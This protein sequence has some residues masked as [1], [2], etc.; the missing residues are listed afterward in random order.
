LAAP[1]SIH[2]LLDPLAT[3]WPDIEQL[4]ESDIERAPRRFVGG[5]NSWIA[6]TFL[7]LRHSLDER[8]WKVTAGPHVE[9]GAITVVHRDDANDFLARRHE[10]FLVVVRADRPPVV[11]CDLAIVQNGISPNGNE[12]FVPLWPQPGLVGRERSRGAGIERIAYHGR[13]SSAP[14]W[15][16]DGEFRRQLAARSLHFDIRVAEWED[17]RAV[18]VAIAARDEAPGVLETKPATKLYNAWIAGVPV[19]AYPE[20][21]YCELRHSAIDFMAIHDSSDVLRCVDLLRANP[22]LYARMA[23]N[24]LRRGKDFSIDAI[25]RRWLDLFDEEIIPSFEEARL[26]VPARRL[27]FVG[28]MVRQKALSRIHKFRVARERAAIH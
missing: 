25:R 15:F 11:A 9:P 28:A 27:W 17:Y 6:Q 8:G 3:R 12:R 2:F 26:R 4:D 16:T 7:R 21:A 19:L 24:G 22:S 1:R 14:E 18:D 20:P 23:A 13:I 10:T 5:R